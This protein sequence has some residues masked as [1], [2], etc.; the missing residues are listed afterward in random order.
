MWTNGSFGGY[1]RHFRRT[2]HRATEA[3]CTARAAAAAVAGRAS[4]GRAGGTG[5]GQP[6]CDGAAAADG[7]AGDWVKHGGSGSCRRVVTPILLVYAPAASPP[8]PLC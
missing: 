3:R 6:G 5:G 4:R 7:G 2:R 1:L 8:A